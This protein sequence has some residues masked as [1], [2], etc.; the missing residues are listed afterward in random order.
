MF[1][2]IPHG[3]EGQQIAEA[4]FDGNHIDG[5]LRSEPFP[6]CGL[7]GIE[8]LAVESGGVQ[9]DSGAIEA[10][11]LDERQR[12]RWRCCH[13]F[14]SSEAEPIP[15]FRPSQENIR[16]SLTRVAEM[17]EYLMVEQGLLP[18]H[19]AA[20]RVMD[21]PRGA[22]VRIPR[23]GWDYDAYVRLRVRER[24][25]DNVP[26][27]VLGRIRGGGQCLTFA[28]EKALQVGDAAVIYA[29]IGRSRGP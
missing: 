23:G 9:S 4:G 19:A 6:G 2:P 8:P 5:G 18:F 17:P 11:A 7:C 10:D 3:H 13:N 1:A 20:G 29:A 24:P 12:D 16:N 22:A 15:G 14:E 27:L 28:A 25:D 26:D 21:N